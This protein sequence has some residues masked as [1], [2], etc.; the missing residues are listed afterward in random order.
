MIFICIGAVSLFLTY[1]TQ[2]RAGDKWNNIL[3]YA[4]AGV[5]YLCAYILIEEKPESDVTGIF[6]SISA[7]FLMFSTLF[8]TLAIKPD[9]LK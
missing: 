4:F 8:V 9:K 6:Y 3:V 2:I 5:T 1:R 7:I